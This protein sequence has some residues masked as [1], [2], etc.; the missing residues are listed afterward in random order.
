MTL[1]TRTQVGIVGAGPAGLVLGR[2]LDLHGIESV[3]LE[4][5]DHAYVEQRVRAGVLEQG[6]ADLLG[7]IGVG[8]R[9]RREGLVHH[10][11]ELR[12]G[13]RGHRIAFDELTGGRG[14]TVYGQQEVVKDLIAA[15]REAGGEL[16][17]EAEAV[18]AHGIDSERPSLRFR[19]GG[20]ERELRCDVIAACDGFHGVCRDALPPGALRLYERDY[21]FGWLGILARVAPSSDELIY[22]HHDRGFA[23]H[24]MRSPELTRLYLQCDAGEDLE[25]WPDERI[26]DELELRFAREGW[27]LG[28]GP[29]IEKLIAPVRSFVAEPMQHGRMF[30]AGDAVHIVPPTGAK[31]LN[32][33]VADVRVL[34]DALARW[35]ATGDGAPL[36][37]YSDTCLRRVWRKQY[38][39]SWMTSMLHRQPD[40]RDG[41]Q[42]R[43]QRAQLENVCSSRAAATMLAENYVGLERPDQGTPA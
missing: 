6:T 10:G 21:A 38:F 3:I 20:R 23:L 30:L 17:F 13:G 35:F 42:A 1:T 43:V 19:H 32:L 16:L 11:V 37:A 34:A 36:A 26:W 41:F 9:M 8:E 7:E 33:A 22:C 39:S 27:E 28:R 5:R 31:G 2:L 25:A 18:S 15:R 12:F 29:I 24:S 40:D 4:A 14:I